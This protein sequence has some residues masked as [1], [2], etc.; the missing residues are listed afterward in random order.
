M[1]RATSPCS[2]EGGSASVTRTGSRT[3]VEHSGSSAAMGEGDLLHDEMEV[4][5]I[6]QA[7]DEASRLK[8]LATDV[9]DQDD[10]ERAIGR[11]V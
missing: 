4:Q 8:D 6:P 9:R 5:P 2:Q 3:R 7:E 10:L 1:D 11:Q